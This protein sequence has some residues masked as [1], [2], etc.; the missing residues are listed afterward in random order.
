MLASSVSDSDLLLV[1]FPNSAPN[2]NVIIIDS[3]DDLA[4]TI[5][6]T[7]GG[8]MIPD[9]VTGN[10]ITNAELNGDDGA[11]LDPDLPNDTLT[12]IGVEVGDTGTESDDAGTVGNTIIGLYGE[13]VINE[14]GDYS[15]DL[16]DTD[17]AVLAL[18]D[19]D[20]AYDVFTYTITDE[21]GKT[22]VTTLTIEIKGANDGPAIA[23][24]PDALRVTEEGLPIAFAPNPDNTGS[25]DFASL[26]TA[27]GQVVVTDVDDTGHTFTFGTPPAML[28]N[29]AVTW[30]GVGTDIL[31]GEVDGENVIRVTMADD[32][33]N[34]QV[35]LLGPIDHLDPTLEDEFSLEVPVTA[36]DSGGKSADTTITVN[37]DA[38]DFPIT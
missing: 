31:T 15:Y 9:P 21:G 2:G 8:G 24:A 1:G 28:G 11:D 3:A 33:G 27:S 22:S 23:S 19:G 38:D 32:Q 4:A 35:E 5:S 17:G 20:S 18:Q 36:T 14:N 6:G 37:C 25:D 30:S 16:D 34:Y 10:V 29:S 26:N 7:M 13:L 12:V